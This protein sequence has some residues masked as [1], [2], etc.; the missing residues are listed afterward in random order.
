M[1]NV[2]ARADGTGI[3]VSVN[4]SEERLVRQDARAF[5][6]ELTRAII[7]SEP[8]CEEDHEKR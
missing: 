3:I 4:G 1:L 2:T 8:P 7:E 5:L 6:K